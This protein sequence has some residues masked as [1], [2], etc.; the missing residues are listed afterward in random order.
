MRL[1]LTQH[2]SPSQSV[3]TFAN[4]CHFI[5]SLAVFGVLF[6]APQL[7][8]ASDY[9]KIPAFITNFKKS[10]FLVLVVVKRGLKMWPA[11]TLIVQTPGSK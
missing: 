1:A 5:A 10:T 3:P 9:M 2:K 4:S 8:E 7:W 6:K 11:R